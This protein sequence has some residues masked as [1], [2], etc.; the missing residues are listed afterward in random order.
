GHDASE[1]PDR[2]GRAESWIGRPVRELLRHE[3]CYELI[4]DAV[5][6]RKPVSGTLEFGLRTPQ[7]FHAAVTPFRGARGVFVGVVCVLHD[8]TALRRLERI[9]ADFVANVSHEM[10]TPLTALHGFIETLRYGSY[11]EPERI[12]KYL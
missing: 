6:S 12:K 1:F 4:R 2:S 8:Q 10:R 3:E 7:I 11:K 9:R 5:E